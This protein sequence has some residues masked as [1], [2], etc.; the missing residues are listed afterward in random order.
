MNWKTIKN[1]GSVKYFNVSYVVLIL[2][3]LIA[4]TIQVLNAKYCYHFSIPPMMKSL[5]V[6]SLIFA[7]AIAIYQYRC[8][9]II[10]DYKN[11]QDY[12]DK[13]LELFLNKA[14]DLKFYIVL[15]Q[16][17]KV[18]Q[19]ETYD[20]I[21]SNYTKISET[22]S[23]TEKTRLRAE[24]DRSLNNVY[25]SSVQSHLEKKYNDTNGQEKFSIYL[26]G[27]LYLSGTAIILILLIIRTL[28]VFS[29]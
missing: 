21:F 15:A 13:N 28:I 10:K 2:V 16:L 17:D 29:V 24:L 11:L 22:T 20:K 8:P 6:A 26:A 9:A 18:T 7:I 25:K 1:F 5:F 19:K 12:L 14:P 4:S 27:L 23:E 3:P